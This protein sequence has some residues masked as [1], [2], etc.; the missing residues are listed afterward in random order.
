M[1]EGK[2]RFG[3]K[4]IASPN[5]T[6]NTKKATPGRVALAGGGKGVLLCTSDL[7]G[8]LNQNFCLTDRGV[9]DKAAI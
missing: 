8:F 3:D 6:P 7:V 2:L 5:P 9:I 1:C 4:A